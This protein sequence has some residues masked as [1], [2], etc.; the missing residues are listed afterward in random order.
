M[1]S[2]KQRIKMLDNLSIILNQMKICTSIQ[3]ISDNTKIPTSTIQRYLNRKDLLLQ[4]LEYNLEHCQQ[5]R[6]QIEIW[7]NNSKQIGHQQGGLTTQK[8]YGYQKLKSGKF[9]GQRQNKK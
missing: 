4:L 7:L 8:R 6:E 3:E 5:M 2:I 1:V 9:N